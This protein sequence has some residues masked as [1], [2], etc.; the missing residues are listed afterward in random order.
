MGDMSEFSMMTSGI[1][2]QLAYMAL[3]VG[4]IVVGSCMY[5]A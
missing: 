5:A 3:L 4:M 1:P 2:W